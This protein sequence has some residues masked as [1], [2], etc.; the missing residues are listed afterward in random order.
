MPKMNWNEINSSDDGAFRRLA[1]GGYVCKILDAEDVKNREYVRLTFDIAEGP[2]A[3]FYSD[4]FGKSHP[5]THQLILSYKP[6]AAGMLKG[7]LEKIQASNPGFDPFAA[8]DADQWGL[9]AGKLFG[10]VFGEEEYEVRSGEHAG[11]IRT[12]CRIQSTLTVADVRDG[13]YTV[14]ELKK[15]NGGAASKPAQT[16]QAG[17]GAYTDPFA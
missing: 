17:E 2:E 8:F 14:P 16:A 15:L 10:A 5:G 12:S 6:T 13:K 1:P 11:E 9:F 4:D 7:R 3:G